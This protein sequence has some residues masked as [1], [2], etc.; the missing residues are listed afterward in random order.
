MSFDVWVFADFKLPT[1]KDLKLLQS[2]NITDVVLGVEV[3][4][5]SWKLKY[6]EE[7]I[8]EAVNKL[9]NRGLQAHLM[10][11]LSRD[12]TDITQTAQGM[13]HLANQTQCKTMLL[14]AE[15][16]WHR[17]AMSS[18]SAA[19]LIAEGFKEKPCDLGVTGLGILN[20]S[21]KHLLKVCDYGIPQAYSIWKPGTEAHWSHS[22]STEPGQLQVTSW[23]SWN[24][25]NKPLI[26]GLSC[27]WAERPPRRGM[28]RMNQI[29]S[30][31]HS[32]ET[33]KVLGANSFAYWS[34][35]HLH[36]NSQADQ[37]ANFIRAIRENEHAVDVLLAQEL[38]VG[39]GYNL[40]SYGPL[41][42][43]VDGKWGRRSQA[44][45]NL[46]R[47]SNYINRT[48]IVTNED[49]KEM[50]EELRGGAN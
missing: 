48:G 44:A 29:D 35:K 10:C 20:P 50:G 47:I 9:H 43:G 16:H 32:L 2:L 45:L 1:S 6:S 30:M 11:W 18:G 46:F 8:I 37:R 26:M 3:E 12:R 14:D 7:R 19:Q 23:R 27:Y 4:Y 13:I 40:G 49:L 39:L 31:Y 17:G 5:R 28:P 15:Y 41:R 24:T 33:S 22:R 21:V 42:N 34:L 25:C 38:L 36:R